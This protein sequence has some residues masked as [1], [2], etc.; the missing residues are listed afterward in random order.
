MPKIKNPPKTKKR[1]CLKC[2]KVFNSIGIHN[3][4]CTPC[5]RE[6]FDSHYYE[7][8]DVFPVRNKKYHE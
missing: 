1:K 5:Q 7:P 3:R 8:I 2:G 4:I 6:N